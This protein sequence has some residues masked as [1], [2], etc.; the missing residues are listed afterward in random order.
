MLIFKSGKTS[1][2]SGGGDDLLVLPI[3]KMVEQ[4]AQSEECRTKQPT[5]QAL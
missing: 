1:R 4:V 5:Q 3:E 2:Q